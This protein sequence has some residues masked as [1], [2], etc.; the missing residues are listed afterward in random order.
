MKMLRLMIKEIKQQF[1]DA[2]GLILMMVFPL[3]L[4]LVLGFALSGMFS[5]DSNPETL[6]CL[7][8]KESDSLLAQAFEQDFLPMS[9]EAHLLLTEE[10]DVDKAKT[11]VENGDADGFILL[12]EDKITVFTRDG[13]GFNASLIQTIMKG[14]TQ[15]FDVIM[16]VARTRPE[17]LETMSTLDVSQ[18]FTHQVSLNRTQ[19]PRALDYYAITM[20]TLIIM[21]SSSS[22]ISTVV[23]EKRNRTL[24]RIFAAPVKNYEILVSKVGGVIIATLLQAIV[25]FLF[26]KLFLGANWGNNLFPVFLVILAEIIMMVSVGIGCGYLFKSHE[27]AFALMQTLIPIMVFLGGG[28]VNLDLVGVGGVLSTLSYI[29]PIKWVNQTILNIIYANDYST[30]STTLVICLSIAVIFI[31]LSAIFSKKELRV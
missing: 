18:G 15:R 10:A 7:Y 13:M 12:G 16:T 22:A 8:A 21:Y 25:V 29:S 28:Y 9:E 2:Q 11:I 1:R 17:A 24:Y 20:L 26:G 6:S 27:T 23:E 30:L 3:V 31:S 14:F 5:E 4:T 19:S